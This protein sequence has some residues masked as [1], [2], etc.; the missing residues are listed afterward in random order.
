M[1]LLTPL[2]ALGLLVV[3]LPL[4]FHLIRRMPR[5]RFAFSSLMFLR[6]SPPR[7]TR[8]SRLDNLLLLLL[9]ALALI[10]IVLAFA[11][12]F[13][14]E[15]ATSDVAEGGGRK[16]AVL[17]D[18][19]ASMRRDNLWPQ[20]VAKVDELLRDLGPQD[21]V[22]LFA[23]DADVEPLVTFDDT[24]PAD[25]RRQIARVRAALTGVS[26]GWAASDLGQALITAAE[27][28][29][30]AG[31][32]KGPG[33]QMTRHIVLIGDLQEGCR[34]DAL[35]A[36]Q[37]PRD[38]QLDVRRVVAAN[39]TN[40]G[41]HLATDRSDQIEQDHDRAIRVRVTN[42]R[43]SQADQFELR[44]VDGQ[45]AASA[46]AVGHESDPP[47]GREAISV[48][49]PP[50]ES[51][52]VRV[53]R[54]AQNLA[55]SQLLLT[56]DDHPFDNALYLVPLRQ[57][58]VS[59][60]YIGNDQPDDAEG[61]RYY[62][63]RAF[64]ETARRKVNLVVR[65][66]QDPL[67]AEDLLAT[68]LVIVAEAVPDEGVAQLKQ[69]LE[70]GGTVFYV[71]QDAAAGK[72]LGAIMDRDGLAIE[73]AAT[74]DYA[75][76]GE[77]AFAHPLFS[78]FADPRFN[79]FT[80][81][82]FWRHRRVEVRDDPRVEVLARFDNGD[83]ALFEQAHQ[84]GRLLVLSSGWHPADGQLARSTKFVPL[85]CG[86]LE[87]AGVPDVVLPQ[88]QIDQQVVLSAGAE[89]SGS[90][91]SVGHQDV[92]PNGQVRKPDGTELKLDG[93]A[94]VF[95]E[96]DQPG[97]YQ[98]RRGD[99]K[100]DFAVNVPAAESRT[101]PLELEQLE[102]LGVQV[103]ERPTRI[104][105]VESRRQMRDLE[106]ESKQKLWRLLIAAA[107]GVLV[108]ETWL[109]GYRSRSAGEQPEVTG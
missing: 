75:M 93:Q 43:N 21:D 5:G 44:W 26:P 104:E 109:A 16:V 90:H 80:K 60:L 74:D 45:G 84:K 105:L 78:P 34:I 96:T 8:K 12:P 51:R 67:P 4:V 30:R 28:L 57:E 61:M 85:M 20:A 72:V 94:R 65:K 42:D 50:G 33:A 95:A 22:E 39:P 3:S 92:S 53:P 107:L 63:Q 46:H 10:L 25:R 91:P 99:V 68:R 100:Q 36:Y 54:S 9:R 58:E 70:S 56:G 69:Y 79:D 108:I 73:E 47:I 89:G 106:L 6:P 83:P 98:L 103:G 64:P 55:A 7:L 35:R 24:A 86:V 81:I 11:R 76:L 82:H 101:A 49:V 40:A 18:T 88:Y 19:S 71:L 14:R 17:V 2:Y 13:S 29:N 62:L 1:S 31:R 66:P 52:I 23:F 41:L 97:V 59:L 15:F 37:W 32:T 38:V 27:E 102:Q 48:Y 77:I 87:R